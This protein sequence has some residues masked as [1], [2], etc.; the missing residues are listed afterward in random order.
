MKHPAFLKTRDEV[1]GQLAL[2]RAQID[3]ARAA[4][5]REAEAAAPEAAP[6]AEAALESCVD[7]LWSRPRECRTQVVQLLAHL[8]QLDDPSLA[9]LCSS[10]SRYIS[11]HAVEASRP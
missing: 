8:S 5:R 7:R 9:M 11:D 4:A 10:F 1:T 6:E 2:L 3:A